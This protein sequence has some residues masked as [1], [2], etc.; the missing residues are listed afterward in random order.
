MKRLALALLLAASPAAQPLGPCFQFGDFYSPNWRE[1][2]RIFQ[3]NNLCAQ[4]F[5]HIEF[6]PTGNGI[7]AIIFNHYPVIAHPYGEQMV[8]DCGLL[9]RYYGWETEGCPGVRYQTLA[10]WWDDREA[11]PREQDRL[12]VHGPQSPGISLRNFPTGL[13]AFTSQRLVFEPRVERQGWPWHWNGEYVRP[14]MWAVL[15]APERGWW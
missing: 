10:I 1:N 6:V 5:A 13:L 14:A 11:Q 4:H 2:I 7:G 9:G 8:W 3:A 15:I 12:M